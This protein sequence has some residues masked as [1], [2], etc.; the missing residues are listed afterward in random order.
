MSHIKAVQ[1]TSWGL[2]YTCATVAAGFPRS[3]P[4][5]DCSGGSHA[6][7][8]CGTGAFGICAGSSAVCLL[9]K[10]PTGMENRSRWD[11]LGLNSIHHQHIL[12]F[13]GS[14]DVQVPNGL[15]NHIFFF[16]ILI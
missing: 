15:S 5:M 13:Y 7:V 4:G 12:F 2:S 11:L 1:V 10:D 14:F 9:G 3:V 6:T 8:A 16:I